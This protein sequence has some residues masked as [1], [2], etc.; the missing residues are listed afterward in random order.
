VREELP[1]GSKIAYVNTYLAYPLMGFNYDHRLTYAPTRK[2]L[3]SF[4]DMPRIP[5]PITGEEIPTHIV[6]VL[7]QD[8]DREQWLARLGKSGA[9]YLVVMTIDPASPSETITPPEQAF[10]DA[11]PAHFERIFPAESANKIPGVVYRIRRD[12]DQVLPT[13]PAP[14]TTTTTTTTP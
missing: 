1:K 8:P 9:R 7:R 5:A 3:G 10:A 2:N 4:L 13:A 11:D 14:A 12:N 6:R